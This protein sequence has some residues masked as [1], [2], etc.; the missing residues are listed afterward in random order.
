MVLCCAYTFG[1]CR[2]FC[3][4]PI[5][6][7][8]GNDGRANTWCEV[9][10]V[11]VALQQYNSSEGELPRDH[12]A[13]HATSKNL[14]GGAA[15]LLCYRHSALL[16]LQLFS[17]EHSTGHSDPGPC[18]RSDD[19]CWRITSAALSLEGVTSPW[20][21]EGLFMRCRRRTLDCGHGNWF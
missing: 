13:C 15:L 14:V 16:L 18:N 17:S 9:F 10:N 2:T 5:L 12:V 8:Q 3:R 19:S 4:L 7:N 20:L 6:H 11:I 1:T 21:L